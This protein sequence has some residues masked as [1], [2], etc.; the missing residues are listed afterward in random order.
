MRPEQLLV[1]ALA[2]GAGLIAAVVAYLVSYQEY[3]RHLPDRRRVIRVSLE[4]AG[5]SFLFFLALG[6]VLALV[7]PHII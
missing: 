6:A 7:L 2:A 1:L 3:S 5:A 4:I